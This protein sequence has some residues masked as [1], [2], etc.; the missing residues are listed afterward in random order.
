MELSLLR[1]LMDKAFY[2]DHRGA[3][4]PNRLFSKDAQKI[5][6][7]ID[8]SMQRYERTITPDEVEALFMTG[9]PSMT[10]AQK[11]AYSGM[12]DKIKREQPMGN[13]IAR[14]VLSKLF[15]Q[16]IGEEIANLG[17]DYVN[18]TKNTLEP[19]RSILEQYGDDFT[20]NL[21]I[22][23]DDIDIDTLLAKNDLE[24]R[25]T[26]NI[27]SLVRKLEG[28]NEGHLIEVG[29]RPNTGKTSF[30][31]SL[32]ASPEGFARQGAN[33]I[34]LC[35]E[36]GTHRVGARYLTAATGMTMQEIKEN[37]TVARDR[38]E[39][40][41]KN[42]KLRDATG[43]DMSWVESVC[44]AYNPDIVVLD[45]GDKFAVTSGFAR[46]D[47]ALKANA[48]H[49]RMIAKQYGCGVF[50]MSQ[51]SAEAEGKV[52]LNQSM[53]EGSRTGKAAEAD[54]MILIA[55]NPVVEGQEEED[56]QRHLNLVKN[57]LTG[58]HGVIHCELDYKTARYLA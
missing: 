21:N 10:T 41:R 8:Q 38:Y 12:F 46:Q 42:I 29:A 7:V 53:M 15:Q 58:W 49:A 55:K 40:I 52:L 27:P 17:F 28:V 57:K 13:D 23:W 51:L 37:P 36:E 1:S 24:A 44:K 18:G 9:N 30:H 54:L 22:Q 20:P 34:V 45:M 48:V 33:C 11:S 32:I 25:W 2:D 56:N 26:F 31:A 3:K 47:E 19:I 43:R 16:V 35:N 5:K 6:Q 14:E 39:P 4:C 50:Y